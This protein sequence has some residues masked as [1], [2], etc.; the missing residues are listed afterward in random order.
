MNHFLR[1][2]QQVFEAGVN[3]NRSPDLRRKQQEKIFPFYINCGMIKTAVDIIL[4][5]KEVPK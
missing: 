3:S 4:F 2:K 1:L 5:Q